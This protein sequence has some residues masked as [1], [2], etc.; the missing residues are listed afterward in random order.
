MDQ[1]YSD[2]LNAHYGSGRLAERIEAALQAAGTEES[3]TPNDLAPLDQFHSGG[4]HTTKELAARLNPKAGETIIDVGGGIG[5][6]ARTLAATY[7][8]SVTVVDLTESF[9]E[10][11]EQL[12]KL[13]GL[14]HLV[15]FHH[16]NALDL[17]FPD[18]S[19]DTGWTQHST[20][21]IED[22]ERLYSELHR[23]VRPGGR[24]ALHEVMA[25]PNQPVHFPVPWSRDP[26]LSFIR[27]VAKMRTLIADAGFNESEWAD[28]TE[29]ALAW[30]QGWIGRQAASGPSPLG[31]H[32]LLGP[33]FREMGRNML[34]NLEEQRIAIV[35]A[36]F[37]RR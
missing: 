30:F 7:G 29:S 26:A 18:E 31:L 37:E 13:L 27:P 14:S 19:F 3:L 34:R 6:P 36:V 17:P 12:T 23:V 22:K 1:T 4:I 25:G 10:A 24:L 9:C 28:T 32:I 35:Q 15:S 2:S 20:M 21:N 5:G 33:E 16:G 8:C 11:G